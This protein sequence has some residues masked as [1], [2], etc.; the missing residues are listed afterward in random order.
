MSEVVDT[1]AK[2][3]LVDGIKECLILFG[4]KIIRK[5]Y[6][7]SDKDKMIDAISAIQLATIESRKFIDD[8]GYERNT[9]LTKLWHEALKKVIAAKIDDNLPEYLYHKA[10]FWGKPKD[11][12][13]NPDTLQLVPKLND[14]DE[15]CEMLL[16]QL[17][18]KRLQNK[19]ESKMI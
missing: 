1:I 7:P 4:K 6:N 2:L 11:W 13:N 8:F 10:Q 14:L 19:I 17:R 12:L 18:N 15:K 9:D 16:M 3:V 5:I